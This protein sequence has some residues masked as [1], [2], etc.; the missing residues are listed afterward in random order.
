MPSLIPP[1]PPSHMGQEVIEDCAQREIEVVVAGYLRM[2]ADQII[3]VH[4]DSPD[5]VTFLSADMVA[6]MF[7][8]IAHEIE[9]KRVHTR[10]QRDESAQIAYDL[11]TELMRKRVE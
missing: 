7:D 8:F 1:R 10:C 9:T 4:G 3:Q 5:R 11:L 6:D 2:C